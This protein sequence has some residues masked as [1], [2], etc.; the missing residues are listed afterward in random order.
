MFDYIKD[1][2]NTKFESKSL[3]ETKKDLEELSEY[4]IVFEELEKSNFFAPKNSMHINNDTFMQLKL[5]ISEIKEKQEI[6]E[7]LSNLSY[8]INWLKV[9]TIIKDKNIVSKA[10]KNIMQHEHSSINTIISE[11]NS[12]KNRIE[13]LENLHSTL[14]DNNMLSLDIRILLRQDFESKLEKL[15]EVHNR[16]KSILLNLSSIFLKLTKE[17]IPK[18][19]K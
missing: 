17:S 13:E 6:R 16:Q 10:I 5:L 4:D 3:E 2:N 7:R 12:L 15:K 8:S 19:K 9:G 14:L 18:N 1:L 11:L